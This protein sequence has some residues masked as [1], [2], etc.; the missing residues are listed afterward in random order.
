MHKTGGI[1]I[2]RLLMPR[3]QFRL[4]SVDREATDGL[5]ARTYRYLFVNN[6][7]P[8][9]TINNASG[10]SILRCISV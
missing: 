10:Q 1:R 9:D 6:T 7:H 4:V 2:A 8:F 3:Q 5:Y